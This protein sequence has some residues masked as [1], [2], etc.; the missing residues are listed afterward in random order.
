MFHIVAINEQ[1]NNRAG[2]V[3]FDFAQDINGTI[4]STAWW[5]R[6]G[7]TE[8]TNTIRN[9]A[10]SDFN[11]SAILLDLSATW[12]TSAT[13]TAIKLNIVDTSSN[14]NSLLMDLQVGG[15]SKFKIDKSSAIVV[16]SPNDGT[17]FISNSGFGIGYYAN[18]LT[19]GGTVSPAA[20]VKLLSFTL[21]SNVLFGWASGGGWSG[22]ADLVLLRENANIL[23]QRNST[24][25]QTVSPRTDEPGF[26]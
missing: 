24:N 13:P 19:I 16:N 8:H 26:D 3:R 10:N 15:I 1:F 22:A 14:A 17:S 12:N 20:Y 25:A 4:S 2:D 11:S 21:A 23:A 7:I 9:Y 6:N 5:Y 18:G